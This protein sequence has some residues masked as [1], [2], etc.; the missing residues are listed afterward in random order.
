MPII[1]IHLKF[2]FLYL[3]HWYSISKQSHYFTKM[4]VHE[5]TTQ[6]PCFPSRQ[7]KLKLKRR[8]SKSN[9]RCVTYLLPTHWNWKQYSFFIFKIIFV[10]GTKKCLHT[11]FLLTVFYDKF[12]K[13]KKHINIQSQQRSVH[14]GRHVGYDVRDSIWNTWKLGRNAFLLILAVLSTLKWLPQIL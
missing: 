3:R 2:H 5:C 1:H 6:H 13:Y 10:R 14:G 4:I 7:Q 8:F 9:Q 12:V 11:L